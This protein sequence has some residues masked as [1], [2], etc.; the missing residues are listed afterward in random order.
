M[1]IQENDKPRKSAKGSK[2]PVQVPEEFLT[3]IGLAFLQKL[4]RVKSHGVSPVF[5]EVGAWFFSGQ[6]SA[7]VEGVA[8]VGLCLAAGGESMRFKFL[9]KILKV[10]STEKVRGRLDEYTQASVA[11]VIDLKGK[12][13]TQIV[14]ELTSKMK[15]MKN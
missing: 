10:K 13:V 9:G 7:A 5:M 6:L 1:T 4:G 15:G 2:A 11:G 3:S 8:S 14:D 12:T